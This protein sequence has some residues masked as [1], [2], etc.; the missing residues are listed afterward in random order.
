[1]KTPGDGFQYTVGTIEVRRTAP[2]A[3]FSGDVVL[4]QR[5]RAAPF[6]AGPSTFQEIVWQRYCY[7][8][9]GTDV[10]PIVDRAANAR[11][12]AVWPT[13]AAATT[14]IAI[15]GTTYDG[16]L[17]G[18]ADSSPV[19]TALCSGCTTS[20]AAIRR[21]PVRSPTS[22]SASR[23]TVARSSPLRHQLAR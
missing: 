18:S 5:T 13:G 8:R 15:C 23:P 12:I 1:V 3:L 19:A 9:S 16:R 21:I 10:L 20:T 2:G 4:V 17:P 7:G 22:A 11:G 14:R 6:A